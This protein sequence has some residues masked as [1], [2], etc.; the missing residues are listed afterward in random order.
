MDGEQK[1]V[2]ERLREL[3]QKVEDGFYGTDDE[4]DGFDVDTVIADLYE[5]TDEM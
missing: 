3:A 4:G 2:C 1:T 5:M